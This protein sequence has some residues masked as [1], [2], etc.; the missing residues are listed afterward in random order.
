MSAPIPTWFIAVVVVRRGDRFLLVHERKHGQRFYLPAGRV[1]PG[2]S[3]FDGALRETLEESGVPVRLDG[4]LRVE[5]TPSPD[6]AMRVRVVFT[7]SPV[8][9]RPPRTVPNE[10]SLGAVWVTFAD[11]DYYPLRGDDARDILRYVAA[12]GPVQPLSTLAFESD[13]WT[14]PRP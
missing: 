6:G 4:I 10:H 7:A 5:H 11:L 13:P 9:D 8:D 2:E 1:E 12:G 3:L 14:W